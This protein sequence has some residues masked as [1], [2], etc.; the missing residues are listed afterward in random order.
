[1]TFSV[2]VTTFNRPQL[3]EQALKGIEGQLHPPH[4]IIVVDDASN[5]DNR[6]IIRQF[7]NLTITYHKLPL[8]SGANMARN[9][10]ILL[11]NQDVV[12]FL[13]DD[14]L[15][16]KDYL[17]KMSDFIFKKKSKIFYAWLIDLYND[18]KKP[19]KKL[20]PNV[21]ISTFLYKNPGSVISNLIVKLKTLFN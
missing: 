4:Q 16:D 21:P 15:W 6:A 5:K 19:G 8:H 3:L 20:Q 14:D 13:D 17:K 9:A 11:A 2:V 18:Y 1:M 7:S 12:A 10:G